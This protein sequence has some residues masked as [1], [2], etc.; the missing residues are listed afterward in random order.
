MFAGVRA[1][2]MP[3]IPAHP[4]IIECLRVIGLYASISED[5]A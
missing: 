5:K 2:R 4:A 1:G 3:T